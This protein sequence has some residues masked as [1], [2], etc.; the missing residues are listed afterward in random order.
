MSDAS[1]KVLIIDDSSDDRVHYERL[2]R[3]ISDVTYVCVQCPDGR[4]GMD[5][6][7]S[8]LFDCVVLDYSLPEMNG[9]DVLRTIRAHDAFL[10]IILL[11]GQ[12]SEAI[13]VEAIRHGAQDYLIK[14]GADSESLHHAI[15]RAIHQ[16]ALRR[17]L[18]EANQRLQ[19]EA[20]RVVSVM[21]TVSDGIITY[22]GTGTIETI[23]SA[24]ARLFGYAPEQMTGQHIK[25]LVADHGDCAAMFLDEARLVG[26]TR[27]FVAKRKDSSVFPAELMINE[28]R[29]DFG[30][31]FV[32]AIRDISERKEN[33][34]I[35][36]EFIATVN[37]ELRTPLTSIR[38]ALGLICGALAN[39]LPANVLKLVKI[40]HS[41]SDRLIYLVNDMLDIDRIISGGMRFHT[42]RHRVSLL[43]RQAVEQNS[44]YADKY[45]VALA[46][47]AADCAIDV[48]VDGDRFN[49]VMSNLLSNAV[50]FSPAGGSVR[51][52]VEPLDGRVRITIDDDGPGIP[53][54]FRSRIFGRF[55]Q[56]DSSS[57]RSKGGSG[58]GLHISK[59]IV[60]HMHG[61]IGFETQL[62]K[63]TRF[64]VE[65]PHAEL[66]EAP[67]PALPK[68]PRGLVNCRVLICEDDDDIVNILKTLVEQAGFQ[69][70]TAHSIAE[71]RRKVSANDY[72]AMT[73]DLMF[74]EE[75][76]LSFI[77]EL[78]RDARTI[79]L[80][81]VV[82][83]A[84]AASDQ[85]AMDVGRVQRLAKPIDEKELLEALRH[86]V[87]GQ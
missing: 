75:D 73:L 77:G 59:L 71:A 14:S 65:F 29:V 12:S 72:D 17:Q 69:A 34:R 16:G 4:S 9:I 74:P 83:S 86:A 51:I 1:C 36:Q 3:K 68:L 26:Q 50:K 60:E 18:A 46:Q 79:A 7:A 20:I 2:L 39:G 43:V 84:V 37:H 57:T 10:P 32:G 24:C 11:T 55:S 21:N 70:D 54:E 15:G 76:G 80:P 63:G 5:L 42:E 13:A 48:D 53:E 19:N 81:I 52:A 62:G 67:A 31:M 30:R 85:R 33:E 40:A 27:E 35:K 82:V 41:N 78:R 47:P 45:Q 44:G 64:W 66:N 22:S 49:Q 8:R 58:L 6:I 61:A 87:P 25:M 28:M 23:N 56:A 38:G